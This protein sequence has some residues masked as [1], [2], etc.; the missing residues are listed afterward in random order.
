MLKQIPLIS[1]N[2]SII[3]PSKNGVIS[4]NTQNHSLYLDI[5][6]NKVTGK[7]EISHYFLNTEV[8]SEIPPLL[9]VEV[10]VGNDGLY[11]LQYDDNIQFFSNVRRHFLLSDFINLYN[12]PLKF[13]KINIPDTLLGDI[14]NYSTYEQSIM[15]GTRRAVRVCLAGIPFNPVNVNLAIYIDLDRN[16]LTT[17]DRLDPENTKKWVHYP[18][19][20][21]IVKNLDILLGQEYFTIP[22]TGELLNGVCYGE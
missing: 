18:L 9:F 4:L 12:E 6:M 11:Y 13:Q 17:M 22:A 20:E 1:T 16:T 14:Q 7:L 19:P 2:I 21:N 15:N 10:V 3:P 8:P 5:I